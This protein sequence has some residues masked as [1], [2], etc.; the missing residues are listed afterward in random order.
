MAV[1]KYLIPEFCNQIGFTVEDL[2]K[3]KSLLT[4]LDDKH[5]YEE[6]IYNSYITN[7]SFTL[8]QEQ[9][10]EAYKLYKESR[11]V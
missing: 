5:K 6:I 10:D 7:G 3:V 1:G 11:G 9:R 4:K 2:P 8:T